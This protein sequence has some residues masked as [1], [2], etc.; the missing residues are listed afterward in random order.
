MG[1]LLLPIVSLVVTIGWD[2]FAAGVTH[3][4]VWPALKLSLLTTSVSLVVVVGFGT[5]LAWLVSQ[6]E[7]SRLVQWLETMMRLPAVL[8]PAVAGV[9][10]LL[11][12]GR[13]GLLGDFFLGFGISIPFSTMAVI[14]AEIFVSAPFFLQ[15]A[16]EAFRRVDQ[17][18][19]LVARSLGASPSRVFLRI[20]I[21]LAL[22]GLIA[23]AAMSWA[24]ALGEFGATVMF[25]GS[26]PG[27]TQTL[28][29]L[30]YHQNESNPEVAQAISIVLVIV[31][32][33]LL[34]SVSRLSQGKRNDYR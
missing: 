21:P 24:R 28:T 4:S 31:A 10:L 8:P 25:A 16:T 19:L 12:F 9:A 27:K 7:N 26:L 23:G 14:L 2:E 32:F 1:F 5:P 30:V 33:V 29:L 6:R 15:A 20:A 34:F 18:Q 11:A 17:S 3:E 22:P 13:S